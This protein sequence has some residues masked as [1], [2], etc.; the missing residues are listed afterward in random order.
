MKR[1]TPL[2][3][4][5]LGDVVEVT[6]N[7][8]LYI[9]YR[10]PSGTLGILTRMENHR[11]ELLP[12]I[13]IHI[14]SNGADV[15]GSR[16]LINS[17]CSMST[18]T[19]RYHSPSSTFLSRV[20]GDKASA[21][22]DLYV[23]T[24]MKKGVYQYYSFP[25]QNITSG[26]DPEIFIETQDG[27][28][29]PA[30]ECLPDKHHPFSAQTEGN[31]GTIRAYWD[32]FQAELST[33]PT[34]CAEIQMDQVRRGLQ[35]I[36]KRALEHDPSSRLSI[37]SLMEISQSSLLDAKPSH[38]ALGCD[39]SLNAYGD[40]GEVVPD[41][42]AL[43]WRFAGGHIHLG[44][45]SFRSAP[46]QIVKMI[47]A[48]AGAASVGMFGDMDSPIR[49]RFYGRAGEYRLPP[50]GIEY[51]VLSNAWVTHPALGFFMFDLVRDA[52]MLGVLNL[53]SKFL[54]GATD[55]S[56]Q[57]II[58]TCDVPAARKY[59]T[60]HKE[61]YQYLW[62]KR[63]GMGASET[64]MKMILNGVGSVLDPSRIVENWMLDATVSSPYSEEATSNQWAPYA[65]KGS[66]RRLADTLSSGGKAL[67]ASA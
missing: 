10:V 61:F 60:R 59:V 11:Q 50:H 19:G 38:I 64:A 39:P 51:R 32:G 37:R 9:P 3:S 8:A 30:W 44:D 67:G 18:G 62:Q 35:V 49:R 31:G 7:S 58:N 47:D 65:R 28:C 5:K 48:V 22:R 42:R 24:L 46:T 12:S 29:L 56:I 17:C 52:A 55:R 53:R 54:P 57:R 34:E 6:D 26:C 21:F 15:F 2:S 1:P 4:L 13:A 45:E 66:F 20:T 23:S 14:S 36:R 63:Y 27:S 33:T 41:P 16:H 40:S 25:H 43:P